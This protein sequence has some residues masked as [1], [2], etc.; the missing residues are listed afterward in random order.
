VAQHTPS[1]PQQYMDVDAASYSGCRP[2][3]MM[4]TATGTLTGVTPIVTPGYARHTAY[5]SHS[6]QLHL[7]QQYPASSQYQQQQ[8]QQPVV[9]SFANAGPPGYQWDQYHVQASQSQRYDY[10]MVPGQYGDQSQY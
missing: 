7:Q 2:G 10:G 9:G 1:H 8:Q 3:T 5:T 4:S 6:E